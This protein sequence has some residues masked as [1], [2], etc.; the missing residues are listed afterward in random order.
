MASV[1]AAQELEAMKSRVHELE[2]V[3]CLVH[4]NIFRF[5]NSL[6]L[7]LALHIKKK[8]FSAVFGHIFYCIILRHSDL[9]YPCRFP[10]CL[11]L[12]PLLCPFEKKFVLV[13]LTFFSRSNL[14]CSCVESGGPRNTN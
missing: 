13:E 10:W 5:V 11:G 4:Y 8:L 6:F 9:L 7:F 12:S 2:R 14:I 3:S 1:A